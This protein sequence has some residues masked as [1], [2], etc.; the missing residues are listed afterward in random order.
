M[1][2][3][4]TSLGESHLDSLTEMSNA[5]SCTP[6][7]KCSRETSGWRRDY[8]TE[9]SFCKDSMEN[10]LVTRGLVKGTSEAPRIF[11]WSSSDGPW[12]SDHQ[13]SPSMILSAPFAGMGGTP[14]D[15]SWSGIADD[16]FLKDELPHHTA[17]AARDI[18]LNNAAS[19][20]AT[21]AEDRYKQK[22]RNL[23]TV[24]SIHLHGEQRRLTPLIPFGNILCRAR[25]F[26]G[27]HAVNGS[28]RAEIECRLLS[29][30][31]NWSALGGFFG[32]HAHVGATDA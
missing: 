25:H 28:K 21:L 14:V 17:E 7:N 2:W 22:L 10:S 24:P 1:G 15:G 20:D 16:L 6:A 4:L 23:E 26:G 29:V 8:K 3:H 30:A 18:I 9:W 5:F 31:V 11:S 27:R 13:T 32:S 19:F 12:K